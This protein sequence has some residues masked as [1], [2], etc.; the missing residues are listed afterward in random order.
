LKKTKKSSD[1]TAMDP[2]A[3]L[4]VEKPEKRTANKKKD[5]TMPGTRNQ[6]TRLRGN[7]LRE[8]VKKGYCGESKLKSGK[9]RK[10]RP[11][12]TKGRT[13]RSPPKP[14]S[15]SQGG[16]TGE[17]SKKTKGVISPGASKKSFGTVEDGFGRGVHQ[18]EWWSSVRGEWAGRPQENSLGG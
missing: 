14:E 2:Y 1:S 11:G 7:F 6:Q 4:R 10:G 12:N 13:V 9:T 5:L 8:H 16:E 18:G 15:D 3:N 17:P